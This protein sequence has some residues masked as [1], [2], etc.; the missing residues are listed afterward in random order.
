VQ[1]VV[2]DCARCRYSMSASPGN[3]AVLL[4]ARCWNA[5]ATTA[6]SLPHSTHKPGV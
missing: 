1:K 4:T 5:C 6:I 3:Q 2:S